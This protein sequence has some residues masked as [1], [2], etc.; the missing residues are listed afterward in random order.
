MKM[1][2][3]NKAGHSVP[4]VKKVINV[5]MDSIMAPVLQVDTAVVAFSAHAH[6]EHII[7]KLRLT[8]LFIASRVN[9]GKCL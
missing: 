6:P 8:Q 9:M 7:R 2:Y 3:Q 4:Y 1:Q 5:Q